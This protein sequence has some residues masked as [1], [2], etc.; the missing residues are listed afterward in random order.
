MI[1]SMDTDYDLPSSPI[2]EPDER[3]NKIGAI[4]IAALYIDDGS[5]DTP[6]TTTLQYGIGEVPEAVTNAILKKGV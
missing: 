1:I 6:G 2:H 4:I 3:A 5:G